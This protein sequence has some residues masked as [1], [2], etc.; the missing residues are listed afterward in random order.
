MA[1]GLT[2]G[3]KPAWNQPTERP[4]GE[5]MDRINEASHKRT[6][7]EAGRKTAAGAA[8]RVPDPGSRKR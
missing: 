5:A 7:R 8:K 6:M 1:Q 4:G 3:E 2:K